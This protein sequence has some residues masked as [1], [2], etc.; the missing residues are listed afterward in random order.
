MII[1]PQQPMDNVV[2][3]TLEGQRV[4]VLIDTG[5]TI[6]IINKELSRKMTNLKVKH[7]N[8]VIL[9]SVTGET[10]SEKSINLE[11]G[12]Y[13]IPHT[14]YKLEAHVLADTPFDIILG[15][16][17]MREQKLII[18]YADGK[19][20]LDGFLLKDINKPQGHISEPDRKLIERACTATSEIINKTNKDFDVT[21]CEPLNK[22][23]MDEYHYI[24]LNN[25]EPVFSKP[26]K[27]PERCKEVL[28]NEIQDLINRKIIRESHSCYASPAFPI[29]K[30]DKSIRLIIDFRKLN[31]KTVKESF[32]FPN[33]DH[34]LTGLQG[35]T[36]FSSLDL[37]QGYYQ[38]KMHENS[39]PLSAFV[40]PF[41]HYEFTKNAIW[42]C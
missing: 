25:T 5:A 4:D 20:K 11:L 9:Q 38:I 35:A 30:A 39:I 37:R 19:M 1:E 13:A 36:K 18:D 32:P 24:T 27:I 3:G 17:F 16:P 8:G 14:K 12:F 6:N 40:T 22:D 34:L 33:I 2:Q 31:K 21:Q 15:T 28:H 42:S 26:Y 23:G 10:M 41:G 7:E 29:L